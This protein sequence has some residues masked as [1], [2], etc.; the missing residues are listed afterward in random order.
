[1]LGMNYLYDESVSNILNAVDTFIYMNLR[2]VL[3]SIGKCIIIVM[4]VVSMSGILVD[5][6]AVRQKFRNN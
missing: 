3:L 4:S 6:V 5:V 1:M 2:S